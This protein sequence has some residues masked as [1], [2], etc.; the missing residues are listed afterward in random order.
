MQPAA[1]VPAYL[2]ANAALLDWYDSHPAP[3]LDT[4]RV[5]L[6]VLPRP[7]DVA[8]TGLFRLNEFTMH[9]WDVRVALDPAATLHPDAVPPL[10]ERVAPMLAVVAKPAILAGHGGTV[11]VTL[12]E[13]DRTFGLRLSD[14]GCTIG[15][16]PDAPDAT[17][18]AP[19]EAWLRLVSGRLTPGHTPPA[20]QATGSLDLDTLRQVFPGY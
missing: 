2:D 1:R 13:P 7:V 19:G 5:D 14:S 18:I 8:T 6:G 4:L 11:R 3:V 20:V 16:L 9:S 12:H 10:L 17:L 15:D